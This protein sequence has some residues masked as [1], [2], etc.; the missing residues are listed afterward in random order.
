MRNIVLIEP[1]DC[2]RD[3]APYGY[4]VAS[5]R[6]ERLA[7]EGLTFRRAFC[8]SPQCSPSRASMLTG[9]PSY[10]NGM[11]SVSHRGF[12]LRDP[13]RHL[14]NWLDTTSSGASAPTGIN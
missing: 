13:S 8:E 2:G 3:F 10:Q 11:F 7:R 14:A 9:T 1:E 6:I 5:P 12:D 4:P